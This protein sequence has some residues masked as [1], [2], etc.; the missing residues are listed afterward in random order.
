MSIL[1]DDQMWRDGFIQ[2]LDCTSKVNKKM[3]VKFHSNAGCIVQCLNT[4]V[5]LP[6]CRSLGSRHGASICCQVH[7]WIS[8]PSFAVSTAFHIRESA[9]Q[10]VRG[11]Q[12][13]AFRPFGD[14]QAKLASWCV[15]VS[16]YTIIHVISRHKQLCRT[17]LKSLQRIFDANTLSMRLLRNKL[18]NPVLKLN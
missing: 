7:R 18:N 8:R 11:V 5:T 12:R 6:W 16:V 13:T 4:L 15:L 2:E 3:R 17:R 9:R 1:C 14:A 10:A